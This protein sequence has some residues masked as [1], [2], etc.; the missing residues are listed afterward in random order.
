M[1]NILEN[2]HAQLSSQYDSDSDSDS[3]SE[4]NLFEMTE[5]VYS[6]RAYLE[7]HDKDNTYADQGIILLVAAIFEKKI[8]IWSMV[9]NDIFQA[10]VIGDEYVE[11]I[12][13]LYTGNSH[14]DYLFSN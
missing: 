1:S 10:T 7:Y 2:I 5:R 9:Q 13:L 14:Y 8:W 12:H 11:S 6:I 4:F 3:D